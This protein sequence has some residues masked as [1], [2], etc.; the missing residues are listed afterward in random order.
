MSRVVTVSG[1]PNA[2]S[3]TALVTEQVA[4]TLT[5]QGFSVETIN[6]RDLPAADLL[7][8]R[9]DSAAVQR[10][11]R[12]VDEARGV[13][14]A[15]PVYKA[16]YSGVLKTFIDLLPQ[17]GLAGKVVLPLATGGS[18]AHVLAIDYALRPVL[19]SL[20]AGLVVG[21]LFVLDRLIERAATGTSV[22]LD[23]EIGARLDAVIAEFAVCLRRH[24]PPAAG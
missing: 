22:V 7:G 4:A 12:L 17:F 24:E 11:L 19:V 21:G 15:T 3:R 6:V 18:L 9:S 13:V 23:P 1:S 2:G 20:G 5:A 16:A 10:A 8:G 14:F